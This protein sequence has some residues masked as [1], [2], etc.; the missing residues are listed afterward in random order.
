MGAFFNDM[1][2][3]HVNERLGKVFEGSV[4]VEEWGTKLF[5]DKYLELYI[6]V[7]QHN[8]QDYGLQFSVQ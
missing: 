5:F 4:K 6:R 2:E 3:I 8:F 1:V 7:T